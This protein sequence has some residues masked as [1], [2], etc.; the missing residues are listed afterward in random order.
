MHTV[1]AWLSGASPRRRQVPPLPRWARRADRGY[2]AVLKCEREHEL[3]RTRACAR[4]AATVRSSDCGAVA[5]CARC[6][7]KAVAACFNTVAGS[8]YHLIPHHCANHHARGSNSN[9]GR[10]HHRTADAGADGGTDTRAD[11]CADIRAD[12][13]ADARADSGTHVLSNC[14]T[15]TGAQLC[16]DSAPG[17]AVSFTRRARECH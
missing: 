15:I 4:E 2:N 1:P 10:I 16:P 13:G 3:A 14:Y 7:A 11:A 6:T 9:P 17:P 5:A 8:N 12:S